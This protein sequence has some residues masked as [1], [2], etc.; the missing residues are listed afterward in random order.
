MH[1][2]VRT[3]RNIGIGTI[4]SF[5][6]LALALLGFGNNLYREAA[7]NTRE[8]AGLVGRVENVREDIGELRGQVWGELSK[9]VSDLRQE[10]SDLEQRIREL[11]ARSGARG[12]R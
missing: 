7:A 8:I 3:W 9:R 12:S 10:I 11:E 2:E 4:V 5:F 6:A 1:S